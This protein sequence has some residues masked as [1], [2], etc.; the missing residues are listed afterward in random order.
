MSFI[1]VYV[2]KLPNSF[3]NLELLTNLS[4]L[5]LNFE[6]HEAIDGKALNLNNIINSVNIRGCTARLGYRI[7]NS[8]IGCGLSHR[9][10]YKKAV[11]S[12][13]E[14]ILILEEDA[15]L[16]NFLPSQI[17]EV[18]QASGPTPT[19]VQLF[20][21]GSRLIKLRSITKIGNGDRLLFDFMPRVVGSGASGYLINFAAMKIA[22]SSPKLNGA[23]D[24]PDWAQRV[25]Q[26]GVYP[27]MINESSVGSTI[28]LPSV[29]HSKY[30]L[31]RFAQFSGIHYFY[32]RKE[33]SRLIDYIKEEI[34]PY[35]VFVCW[36]L[37][38]SKYLDQEA[39]GPQVL[40]K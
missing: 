14:W 2:I 40:W 38:G 10:V 35:L 17:F 34:I 16:T 19:I 26:R 22:L 37:S 8:L 12:Q 29:T 5:G 21:R 23:P 24:W 15:I 18:I 28:H 7:S 9:A 32:Y 11:E 36:R 6:V 1:P 27:W 20:S 3:R 30:L 4:D 13:Y 33:Y 39:S 25:R 31:R